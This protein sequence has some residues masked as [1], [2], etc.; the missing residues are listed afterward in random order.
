[1]YTSK[2]QFF[3]VI[4]IYTFKKEKKNSPIGEF[5]FFSF[6]TP[7]EVGKMFRQEHFVFRPKL[8]PK[9]FPNSKVREL[10]GSLCA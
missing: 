3:F 10:L 9:K 7:W 5:F 6:P 8:K 2:K 4:Q 1:M